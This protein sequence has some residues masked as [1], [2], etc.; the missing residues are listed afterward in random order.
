MESPEGE[1]LLR[2]P[3]PKSKRARKRYSY[4]FTI[5]EEGDEEDKVL[6]RLSHRTKL[7]WTPAPS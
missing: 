4:R 2:L 1:I 7:D 5:E 6:A 3:V